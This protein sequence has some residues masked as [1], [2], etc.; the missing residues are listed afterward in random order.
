MPLHRD[1]LRVGYRCKENPG[2]VS[3]IKIFQDFWKR[4]QIRDCGAA[5]PGIALFWSTVPHQGGLI[6]YMCFCSVIVTQ[7]QC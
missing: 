4:E 7:L 2:H 3:D 5:L 6:G 1:S